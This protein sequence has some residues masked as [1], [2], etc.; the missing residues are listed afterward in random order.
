MKEYVYQN[1]MLSEYE[2]IC[3]SNKRIN[4]IRKS[5]FT[6]YAERE[7]LIIAL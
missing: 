7:C 4:I 5:M 2:R 6:I 1:K 3:L